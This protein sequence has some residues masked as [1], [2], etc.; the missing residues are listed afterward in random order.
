MGG[1]A[2]VMRGTNLGAVRIQS[3]GFV[4]AADKN[5]E[6]EG[7]A[8]RSSASAHGSDG[9]RCVSP[10][11][12]PLGWTSVELSSYGVALRSGG[13]F[14]VHGAMRVS[15]LL[16]AAGPVAGGTRVAV[17]GS[18]FREAPSLR[19]RFESS[20]ATAVARYVGVGQLEC[21]APPSAGAGLRVV[22]VSM[23]GQQFSSSGV[24]FTY[25]PA[26]AVSS[27]WPSRGAAEGGTA[28]TVLGSGF[29]AAAEAAGALLC[30]W[31]ASVTAAAYVSESAL[32]CNSTRTPAGY[33]A[34]EVSTNG[35]EYTSDGSVFIFVRFVLSRVVPSSGPQLGGTLVTIFCDTS[36]IQA[37]SCRFGHIAPTAA[38]VLSARSIACFSPAHPVTGWVDL[39]FASYSTFL[40][41]S[42]SFVFTSPLFPP[43][44][45]PESDESLRVIN[46]SSGPTHGGTVVT[47]SATGVY[48]SPDAMCRFGE[49]GNE[50]LAR[51]TGSTTFECTS[52]SHLAALVNVEIS[53]NGQQF[54]SSFAW[55]FEYVP[56]ITVYSVLPQQGPVHGGTSIYVTGSYFSPASAQ[57]SF[58]RFLSTTSPATLLTT[59]LLKCQ[60]PALAHAGYVA[61]ELTTNLQDFS[62][63]GLRFLFVFVS[64]GSASPALVS[65]LGGTEIIIRGSH[66]TPPNEDTLW[67]V[68]GTTGPAL[69]I[70]E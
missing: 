8:A 9:V 43:A 69:A 60:T 32:S 49:A 18:A 34:L 30:R 24:R 38:S 21:A 10:G 48:D 51:F 20:G 5:S 3:C 29:S 46:P 59:T 6:Q 66:F 17:L 26:A 42:S 57:S 63:S 40:T 62:E 31:N 61:V 16:P 35:R 37:L 53:L 70:W 15:A 33:V 2:I 41:S 22:E 68:F 23:N 7:T 4:A 52:P 54:S 56:A 13:S 55:A 58:C 1:T 11:G 47:L 12:L 14:F 50:V 25:R 44:S 19:C 27:V 39:T 64:V 36:S 67:C 65:Q 45:S 28:V